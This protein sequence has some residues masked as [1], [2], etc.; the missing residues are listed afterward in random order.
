MI[1]LK[2]Y[3]YDGIASIQIPVDVVFYSSGKVLIRGDSLTLET[4]LGSLSIAARLGNTRRSIYL[5]GGGKLETDDNIA[6]DRV[7][8]YFNQNRG[9]SWLHSLEK[10]W[11]YVISALALTVVF[12][13]V[14]IEFGV[15]VAAQY[16]AKN[17]PEGI[18]RKIGEQALAQLDD[19]LFSESQTDAETQANLTTRLQQMTR[20][21]LDNQRYRLLFR[22]SEK[23]GAN[24]LALPGGIILI[25][26]AMLQLAENDE[27]LLAVFAHEI[28][29]IEHQHG[30]RSV[31]QNSLTALFMAG[32]LGDITSVT[33]MAVA[34]PTLLVENRYSRQFELD[35]D[36]YAVEL[37]EKHN[38][39]LE[40]FIR[41]LNLL[42]QGHGPNTEFDYM[43]SHPAMAKRIA[44]INDRAL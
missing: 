36:R 40:H 42:E 35:A 27:Q 22:D 39:P 16:V 31:L 29:H 10:N 33:S 12:V 9:Y 44:A 41:I 37:L 4:S 23:M 7:C 13:W 15:P 1:T 38:I 43:S 24:A 30:L 25:T 6:I 28:G 8:R 18:E 17:L 11:V 19:W 5:P 32:L 2:G 21:R 14:A 3:Y 26:D 20:N 34:L